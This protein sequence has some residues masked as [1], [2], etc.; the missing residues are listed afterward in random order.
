MSFPSWARPSAGSSSIQYAETWSRKPSQSFT[1]YRLTGINAYFEWRAIDIVL[2]FTWQH[3]G[4]ALT[5]D[6]ETPYNEPW[7]RG[8]CKQDLSI[9][10]HIKL[11]EN[12]SPSVDHGSELTGNGTWKFWEGVLWSD[13]INIW[14]KTHLVLEAGVGENVMWTSK[15]CRSRVP[16]VEL[17][18]DWCWASVQ[19]LDTE[20][21]QGEC[22]SPLDFTVLTHWAGN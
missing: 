3:H 16:E 6:W 17:L 8:H 19:G 4:F 11:K 20:T 15:K 7:P 14:L 10:S 5:E 18:M 21:G 9:M 1:T 12:L 22:H 13:F 2:H